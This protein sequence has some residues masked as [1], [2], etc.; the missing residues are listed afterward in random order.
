MDQSKNKKRIK[1]PNFSVLEKGK[2]AE[3]RKP[4]WVKGIVHLS[5][6]KLQN[7]L[8]FCTRDL[9]TDKYNSGIYFKICQHFLPRLNKL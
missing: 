9:Y 7:K 6:K 3:E 2:E 1:N 4:G 5:K 8:Y